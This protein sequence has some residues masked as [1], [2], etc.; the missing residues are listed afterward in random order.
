MKLNIQEVADSINPQKADTKIYL[1][2][3]RLK[4]L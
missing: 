2:A 1:G 4:S 3:D